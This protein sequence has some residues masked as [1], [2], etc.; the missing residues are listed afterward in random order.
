MVHL[1]ENDLATLFQQGVEGNAS[2]FT[3]L[4]RR[5]VSK[6][7][8]SDPGAAAKLAETL[9]YQAGTR[10]GSQPVDSESRVGLLT[11][12]RHIALEHEPV[13]PESVRS[14]LQQVIEERT[15]ASLLR[16][17]GLEPIKTLL[18]KGPPGVGK[19]IATRWL[20]REL[21]V[22]LL[23]LDLAS[24]M[25][26]LLG[27]TGTNIRSVIDYGRSFPCVL[28]LDEFDAIAKRRDDD[29]DVGELKRLVTVL[30]QAI[31]SW[32]STSLL[33]AATNH[34]E[35]LDPAVWR[36]F[37]LQ[38][39]FPIPGHEAA[40]AFFRGEDFGAPLSNDLAVVYLG[41][42]YAEL[43]RVVQSARKKAVLTHRTVGDVAL[44]D[45]LVHAEGI[46]NSAELRSMKIR[47]LAAEGMSHRKIAEQLGISHPTVGRALKDVSGGSHA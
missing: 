7:K 23:T 33:V 3:L 2:G 21:E 26:S 15:S 13:W 29:R 34:S 39:D 27:K 24:V 19:T 42:S 40:I 28:L 35:L 44:E 30:L 32:P 20:A 46:R 47:K 18:F 31:D 12:E 45:A 16:A 25:S 10:A 1:D 5:L 37:D 6:L 41:A 9:G 38:L 8:K 22:P 17:A 4:A 36:R 43:R 14:G 11:E